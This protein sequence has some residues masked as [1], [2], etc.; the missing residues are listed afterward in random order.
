MGNPS[1]KTTPMSPDERSK[2]VRDIAVSKALVLLAECRGIV[3]TQPRLELYLEDL[4]DLPLEPLLKAIQT[5]RRDGSPFFPQVPELRVL[6]QPPIKDDAEAEHA[7]QTLEDQVRRYFH[8]DTGFVGK[9]NRERRSAD[10]VPP[11]DP[12]TEHALR[13]TG[14]PYQVWS[15]LDGGEAYPF[16]KKDFLASWKRAP[17]V[18]LVALRAATE[19]LP[20]E[21]KALAEAKKM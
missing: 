21:I 9:W 12:R 7:W 16:L 10:P 2:I 1:A 13:A 18:D 8:P 11:L 14:G 20:P 19:N 17:A 6:V 3:L 5:L 4:A 15:N